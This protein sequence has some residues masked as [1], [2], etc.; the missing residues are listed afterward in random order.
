MVMNIILYLIHIK[1]LVNEIGILRQKGNNY[2]NRKE[3]YVI[4]NSNGKFFKSDN[5]S[6]GY[7]CFI[8][9]FE[10]CEKYNSKQFAE[11]FLKSN[12]ATQ[13]FQK[14]FA[15]CVVKKVKMIVE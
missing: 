3:Y 2:M 13:M 10:F 1:K 14:E 4:Q 12:Y 7:P 15:D 11:D 6:G 8:D 5:L 9:D